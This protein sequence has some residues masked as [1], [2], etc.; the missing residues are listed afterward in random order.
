M[1]ARIESSRQ[2]GVGPQSALAAAAAHASLQARARHHG[3][4]AALAGAAPAFPAAAQLAGRWLAA[5]MLSNQLPQEVLELIVASAFLP[6]WGL[7]IPGAAQTPVCHVVSCALAAYML[8]KCPRMSCKL[9]CM[10]CYM[11][12]AVMTALSALLSAQ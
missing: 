1:A 10:G 5:Q 7:P 3:A 12:L 9:L 11:G 8:E 2:A 6:D 4:M